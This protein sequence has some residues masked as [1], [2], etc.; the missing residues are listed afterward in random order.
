MKCLVAILNTI[1]V[2][3]VIIPIMLFYVIPIHIIYWIIGKNIPEV[4]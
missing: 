3:F 1:I 4:K 2:L